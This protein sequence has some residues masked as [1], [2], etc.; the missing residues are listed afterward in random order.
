MK[1][2]IVPVLALTLILVAAGSAQVAASEA[3]VPFYTSLQVHPTSAG[4]ILDASGNPI[5]FKLDV[6]GGGQ[7]THLGDCTWHTVMWVYFNGSQHGDMVFTAANGGELHGAFDGHGWRDSEGVSH[8]E[9]T[10]RFDG[11][12]GRFEH[13]T[14][15]G[16]YWGAA[17][18][19][20][21]GVLY[22]DGT[23]N[24]QTGAR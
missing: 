16:D 3:D 7:A 17:V 19:N 5:G 22:F 15:E 14:G 4:P 18:L 13:A 24:L 2:R 9:G 20:G 10:Y 12:T 23:L 8:F 11:G 6:P 1:A 21:G